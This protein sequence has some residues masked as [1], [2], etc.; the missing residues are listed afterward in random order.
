MRGMRIGLAVSGLK[1][2]QFTLHFKAPFVKWECALLYPLPFS[3]LKGEI[4]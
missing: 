2:Y 4:I 1:F 3:A